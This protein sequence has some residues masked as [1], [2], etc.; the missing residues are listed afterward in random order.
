MTTLYVIRV[1]VYDDIYSVVEFNLIESDDQ[2]KLQMCLLTVLHLIQFSRKG[3]GIAKTILN[4]K[5][6]PPR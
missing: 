4:G 5:D 3:E 6:I 1:K 2:I